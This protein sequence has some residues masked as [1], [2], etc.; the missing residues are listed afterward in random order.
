MWWLLSISIN[1]KRDQWMT[2]SLHTT[3][4]HR[5]SGVCF[6]LTELLH[7]LRVGNMCTVVHSAV[8][9]STAV[10]CERLSCACYR[11]TCIRPLFINSWVPEFY[12]RFII[13]YFYFFYFFRFLL[14]K[15]HFILLITF[16]QLYRIVPLWCACVYRGIEE[17]TKGKTDRKWIHGIIPYL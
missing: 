2:F 10:W 15:F 12:F 14:Q 16:S 7:F 13:F 9:C 17:Q 4:R 6:R 11:E 1:S 3:Y 8:Q 5:Q